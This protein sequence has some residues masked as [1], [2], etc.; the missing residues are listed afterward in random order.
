MSE[1]TI[2]EWLKNEGDSVEIGEAIF[3]VMTDKIAIEVEA[4]EE[5][6]LLKKTVEEGESAP[7]NAIVAYI[8]EQNEEIPDEE[9]EIENEASDNVD[10]TEIIQSDSRNSEYQSHPPLNKYRAT[11]SARRIARERNI[12]LTQV[13]GTGPKGRIQAQDVRDFEPFVPETEYATQSNKHE[14]E[15]IPWSSSRKLIAQNM[16]HSKQTIPHVT[17]T[18]EVIM[19]KALKFRE[20][21]MSSVEQKTEK[22]LSVLDIIVKAAAHALQHYS[23]FNST[24][25]DNGIYRHQQ[26]NIGVAVAL[27]DG[28]IVPVIKSVHQKGLVEIVKETKELANKA[29][30]GQLALDDLSGGTFTISSLGK[31]RVTQFTPIINA[32]EVAILGVGGI[33]QKEKIVIKDGNVSVEQLPALQLSLSFDHRVIDG[34]PA[35]EFLSFLTETLENPMNL[36]L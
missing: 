4:Y 31:S 36:L 26:I 17:M 21:I 6:I 3:E 20:E 30:S 5:G 29:R 24:V 9:L 2:T 25:D 18:S 16:L 8:G 1:G 22:R 10:N 32:P 7:V 11:P 12:S 13:K 35:A 15:F 23:V 34:A 19:E 27:E 14:Y 28:L 33:Y